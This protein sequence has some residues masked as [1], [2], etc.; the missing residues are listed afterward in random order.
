MTRESKELEGGERGTSTKAT[1]NPEKTG[2]AQKTKE[3]SEETVPGWTIM[4]PLRRK[5][6]GSASV[7]MT[8]NGNA[9]TNN[10]KLEDDLKV[11]VTHDSGDG[12]GEVEALHEVRSDDELLEAEDD[13]EP[14]RVARQ[15]QRN[16]NMPSNGHVTERTLSGGEYKVYKRRW[17]GLVQLVLLN[18]VVSWDVS[19]PSLA[20]IF[21]LD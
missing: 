14:S 15:G 21:I 13:R 12:I 17:F 16:D 20:A 19:A 10:S 7:P 8:A 3:T 11:T 6:K 5:G 2:F 1:T 18:I 9:S 4:R